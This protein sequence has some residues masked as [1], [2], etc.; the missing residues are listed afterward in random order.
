MNGCK[1][2]FILPEQVTTAVNT[3]QPVSFST[4]IAPIFSA[5]DKC[6]AC[7]KTGGQSPDLTSANAFAQI[8]SKVLNTGSPEASLIYVYPNPSNSAAHTWVKYTAG[9]AALV[10]QWIKEGAKNN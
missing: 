6:T 3:G 9:E 7:H 2:D 1:Y 8:T 5:G 10:L 4:Q